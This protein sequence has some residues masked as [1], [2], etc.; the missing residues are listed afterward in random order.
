MTVLL[1]YIHIWYMYIYQRENF[2]H[3]EFHSSRISL[4]K[5]QVIWF[6]NSLGLSHM[7]THP[8]CAGLEDTVKK[9]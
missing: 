1:Y 8:S 6:K 4:I 2:T 3:Q 9:I 7:C 5:A